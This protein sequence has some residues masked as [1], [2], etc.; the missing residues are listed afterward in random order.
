MK[1]GS[2]IVSLRPK[3]KKYILPKLGG[4]F[5]YNAKSKDRP[6]AVAILKPRLK[7][8]FDSMLAA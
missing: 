5:K 4:L 7:S 3:Q 6:T 1:K 8:L 2:K